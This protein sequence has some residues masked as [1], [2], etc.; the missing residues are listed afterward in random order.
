MVLGGY[1]SGSYIVG[2]LSGFPGDSLPIMF[3][4]GFSGYMVLCSL[5]G[6]PGFNSI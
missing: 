5:S 2:P 6:F 1:F 4:S 3:L